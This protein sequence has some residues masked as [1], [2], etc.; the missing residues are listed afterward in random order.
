MKR[1]YHKKFTVKN[2]VYRRFTNRS[3]GYTPRAIDPKYSEIA[4]HHEGIYNDINRIYEITTNSVES[5]E[6]YDPTTF[7]FNRYSYRNPEELISLASS[8]PAEEVSLVFKENNKLKYTY[9]FTKNKLHTPPY[10][11]TSELFY[12]GFYFFNKKL[13]HAYTISD[14]IKFYVKKGVDTTPVYVDDID[15]AVYIPFNAVKTPII[16]AYLPLSVNTQF[17]MSNDSY[18]CRWIGG[19]I[20]G[21][22]VNFPLD[23]TAETFYWMGKSINFEKPDLRKDPDYLDYKIFTISNSDFYQTKYMYTQARSYVYSATSSDPKFY[24]LVET[25]NTGVDV[26][27]N[28][29]SNQTTRMFVIDLYSNVSAV[30]G[31]YT[32][33]KQIYGLD[34][35]YSGSVN[36]NG[37][38]NLYYGYLAPT[39]TKLVFLGTYT[40]RKSIIDSY[41]GFNKKTR[42]AI[43]KLAIPL[44]EFFD[45]SSKLS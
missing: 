34:Y 13:Y 22:K 33:L 19:Y 38:Y 9:P 7:I 24:I 1:G 18:T 23:I 28:G 4:G 20:S 15:C 41:V 37:G 11:E 35:N 27:Y 44:G 16:Q 2:Q 43:K 12:P 26:P 3:K 31:E 8:L 40:C 29:D 30:L 39:N 5:Q 21:E 45:T 14:R 6:S 42:D 36:I 17:I 32:E 10:Y 25:S